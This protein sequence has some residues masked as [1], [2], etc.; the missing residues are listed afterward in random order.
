[1]IRAV[2][3]ANVI[4]SS[5]FGPLGPSRR[6]FDAWRE[7]TFSLVTSPGI[8]EEVSRR[9]AH[10]R[11]ARRY[12]V[13]DDDRIAIVGLLLAQAIVTPG[14]RELS[15]VRDPTDNK[16]IAAALEVGADY[17]VTGDKDLLTISE[18]M[19]VTILSPS[20]FLTSISDKQKTE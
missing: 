13:T 15:V 10:P 7:G 8:I 1:V 19:G 12:S 17:I 16:V 5:V 9:L 11:I 6:I 3:D 4:I 20:V 14:S 2:V 18:Y